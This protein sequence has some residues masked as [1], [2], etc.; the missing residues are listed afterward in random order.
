LAVSGHHARVILEDG[1]FLVEDLNSLSGTFL[2]NQRIRKSALK[3]GDEVVIGKH[4]LLFR[5]E[6]GK[7]VEELA[8]P[9]LVAAVEASAPN[10][11]GQTMVLDTK[12]RR[13]FLAKVTAIATEGASEEAEKVGCLVVLS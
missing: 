4:T 12:K 5:E 13:E 11:P 9:V 8:A 2:N 3:D 7:P 10:A 6:G 1:R